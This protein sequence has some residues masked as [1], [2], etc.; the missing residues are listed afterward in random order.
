VSEAKYK[1]GPPIRT[2]IAFLSIAL[3]Q[4]P[5]YCRH[6]VTTFGWYQNWSLHLINFNISK[7]YLFQ[8]LPFKEE[9]E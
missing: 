4:R 9:Q 6:K 5:L 3:E 7:R 8:A 2:I 1:K